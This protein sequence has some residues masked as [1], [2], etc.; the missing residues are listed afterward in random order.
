MIKQELFEGRLAGMREVEGKIE[1]EG[2]A[3][4]DR[5]VVGEKGFKENGTGLSFDEAEEENGR[6]MPCHMMAE[7]GALSFGERVE[8]LEDIE[9]NGARQIEIEELLAQIQRQQRQHGFRGSWGI[10]GCRV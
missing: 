6:Q 10:G 3:G 9:H 8:V 5:R 2:V 7:A 1:V 4:R